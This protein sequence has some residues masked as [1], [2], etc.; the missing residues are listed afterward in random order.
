V[1]PSA[2]GAV[3]SISA[4]GFP[5]GAAGQAW[6][7]ARGEG[8][9]AVT[10]AD[11][12]F[13]GHFDS[14]GSSDP[15]GGTRAKS[16]AVEA[17]Y[18]ITDRLAATAGL[19]YIATRLSGS[20]PAGVALG[21]LDDGRYHADFQ[22]VRV[23]LRFVAVPLPI[24]I[25]PLVGASI[26]SHAYEVIGEAVPGKRTREAFLGTNVGRALGRRAYVHCRYVF[27]RVEK[28]VPEVNTLDRSTV[29][30]EAGG[31]ATER[32]GLRALAIRQITHG[33]L[34]L[35]D[36]RTNPN[37]F[38]TH[39]RAART[40]YLNVGGG[41]TFEATPTVEVYAVFLKTVSGENAHRARSFSVGTSWEFGGR[42]GRD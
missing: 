15:F 24:T 29:E 34:D 26:P 7:P 38:R 13:D 1:R 41:M 23:E 2:L 37:F 42:F 36:M 6:L 21:P 33:G 18:A 17:T 4:L 40:N 16:I 31:M 5:A 39:D 35:E 11:Y 3:V 20:F 32:L 25:T 9:V 22:D 27:T 19:P 30:V 28:V 8:S 10:L 14:D 12:A